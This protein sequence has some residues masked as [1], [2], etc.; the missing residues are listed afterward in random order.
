MNIIYMYSNKYFIGDIDL[1]IP[2]LSGER[3]H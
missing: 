3:T 2:K 1:S